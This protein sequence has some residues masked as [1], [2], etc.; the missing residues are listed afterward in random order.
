LIRKIRS[1]NQNGKIQALAD[2]DSACLVRRHS[3][4]RLH[5]DW[6]SPFSDPVGLIG[7]GLLS[8]VPILLSWVATY[9]VIEHIEDGSWKLEC[10]LNNERE[11][12]ERLE[13]LK[14]QR[15]RVES[16]ITKLTEL[17]GSRGTAI[18]A[19]YLNRANKQ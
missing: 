7:H 17:Y 4:S 16:E 10:K 19:F 5:L 2:D 8:L 14:E 18:E 1:L 6:P 11:L 9:Y 3:D 15:L 13:Q 12:E